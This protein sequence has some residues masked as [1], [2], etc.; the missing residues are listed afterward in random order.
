MQMYKMSTKLMSA[1]AITMEERWKDCAK[2]GLRNRVA[3]L[4]MVLNGEKLV[5][6]CGRAVISWSEQNVGA[7]VDNRP[8]TVMHSQVDIH[9][10]SVANI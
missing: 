5:S 2:R 4:S 8:L 3:L 7:H 10:Y 1:C 9:R 6:V